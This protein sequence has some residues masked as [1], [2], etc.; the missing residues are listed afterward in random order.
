MECTPQ[1]RWRDIRFVVRLPLLLGLPALAL[2]QQLTTAPRP[3]ACLEFVSR[4]HQA[5]GRVRTGVDR[6][7]GEGRRPLLPVLTSE[8]PGF[9]L[10]VE[11][12][13]GDTMLPH[14][15]LVRS[16]QAISGSLIKGPLAERVLNGITKG[17]KDDG[18]GDKQIWH[19]AVMACPDKKLESAREELSDGVCMCVR[20]RVL[21][22]HP[23]IR[24][25]WWG[26]GG[27]EELPLGV[28]RLT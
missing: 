13:H 4:F 8:C 1:H 25:C 5:R 3:Q 27:S 20:A 9:V 11:K 21:S 6:Q 26:G 22:V 12:T 23:F 17:A 28:L 15:S 10:F 18:G 14:L 16:V 7:E 24:L 2:P 19:G